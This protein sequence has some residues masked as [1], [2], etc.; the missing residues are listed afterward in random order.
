MIKIPIFDFGEIK[1][2][3]KSPVFIAKN[4]LYRRLKWPA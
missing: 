4:L 1:T 3:E 2:G